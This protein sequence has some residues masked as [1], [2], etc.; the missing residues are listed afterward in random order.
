MI[1]KVTQNPFSPLFHCLFMRKKM[2]LKQK[3]SFGFTGKSK[4][5]NKEG[6]SL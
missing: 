2:E 1:T 6:S 3:R 4:Y 5:I